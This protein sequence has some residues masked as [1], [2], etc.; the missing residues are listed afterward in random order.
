MTLL[1]FIRTPGNAAARLAADVEIAQA[2][3]YQIAHGVRPASPERAVQI[4]RATSGQVTRRD[5]RPTDWGDIWPE[6]IDAEHPWMPP[7]DREDA[8]K[9]QVQA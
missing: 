1:E 9:V 5:L 8:P 6:L 2:Y 7:G 3:V 4:E